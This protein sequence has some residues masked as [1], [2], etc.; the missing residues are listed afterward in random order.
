M[1]PCFIPGAATPRQLLLT[2]I[3]RFAGPTAALPT[4]R[5]IRWRVT[6]ERLSTA[7]LEGRDSALS[8]HLETPGDV[9]KPMGFDPGTSGTPHAT[10]AAVPGLSC[11]VF[12]SVLFPVTRVP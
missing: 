12:S 1:A 8:L 11:S 5:L 10:T 7:P 2:R 3:G 6:V 9:D 4:E